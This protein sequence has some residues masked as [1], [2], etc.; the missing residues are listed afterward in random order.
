VTVVEASVVNKLHATAECYRAML[1][2]RAPLDNTR[3]QKSYLHL[4]RNTPT[5]QLAGH[6]EAV[7]QLTHHIKSYLDV[8]QT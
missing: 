4:L 5:M 2:R 6:A 1:R 8:Y 3:V 7:S